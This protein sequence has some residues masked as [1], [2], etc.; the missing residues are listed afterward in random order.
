MKMLKILS[1]NIIYKRIMWTP[2]V[3]VRL[4]KAS[5]AEN[6]MT[7][8]M[9]LNRALKEGDIDMAEQLSKHVHATT[10]SNDKI[11]SLKQTYDKADKD[12]LVLNRQLEKE[13]NR[14]PQ[15]QALEKKYQKCHI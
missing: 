8:K 13:L 2:Y 15:N 7:T 6:K 9:A 5:L 10:E 11:S 4:A 3:D 12:E 1:N 14:F